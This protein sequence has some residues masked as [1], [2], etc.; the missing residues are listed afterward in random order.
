[1]GNTTRYQLLPTLG[2]LKY[3]MDKAWS[4]GLTRPEIH[5]MTLQR[6]DA[7]WPYVSRWAQFEITESWNHRTYPEWQMLRPLADYWGRGALV[8]QQGAARTDVAFL[9]DNRTWIVPPTNSK[10][11]RVA[12]PVNDTRRLEEKGFTIGYVDPVGVRETK[13][14]ESGALFPDGPAYRAIVI[15][16]A[17]QNYIDPMAIAG[18]TA[19][20]LDR[21]SAKGLWVVFVGAAPVRGNSGR[22]PAAEDAEVRRA[23]ANILARR[24]TRVVPELEDVAGAL[25]EIGV[26]PASEWPAILS[27]Q[28]HNLASGG[29]YSQ[30]RERGS[31]RYFYLWNSSEQRVRFDGSF[32]ADGSVFSLDLWSGEIA[33][34]GLYRTDGQRTIVPLELGPGETAVIAFTRGGA[35]APHAESTSADRV[36]V[37]GGQLEIQ[38]AR[39]GAHE[40]TIAGASRTIALAEVADQPMRLGAP[41][42]LL[43]SMSAPRG[44]SSWTV[45]LESW[46]PEGRKALPAV[47]LDQGLKP[48]HSIPALINR[49][50]IATYT[51]SVTLPASWTAPDRGVRMNL[52]DISG[53][54]VQTY[55]N[56]KLASANVSPKDGVQTDITA[57]LKPGANEI[58][59]VF[60]STLF[61]RARVESAILDPKAGFGQTLERFPGPQQSGLI[62][63][64]VL[65][66]YARAKV[67]VP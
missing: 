36:V 66:P 53:G 41:P 64:V 67:S 24:T 40:V 23:V 63:P 33:P 4:A 3:I 45:Q 35:P 38:D 25:R 28:M 46:G 20:A 22:N 49:S 39:G 57:L 60:A 52:G 58:K 6:K 29:V 12:D 48:W 15:D 61:N 55:V 19:T 56:G 59:V 1:M 13:T 17:M 2:D 43:Q 21:A 37:S 18:A 26:R 27:P 42:A 9:R 5:G 14:G 16:G 10:E 54:S 47:A 30:L 50:G 51:A 34:V 8:L 65:T 11:M 32:A 44:G 31:T 7:P 62:G